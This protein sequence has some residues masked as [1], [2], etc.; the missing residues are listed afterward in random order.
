[1]ALFKAKARTIFLRVLKFVGYVN[2]RCIDL[3]GSNSSEFDCMIGPKKR[4][5]TCSLV[6]VDGFLLK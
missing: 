1:M 5:D 6:P 2:Y 3:G 4:T